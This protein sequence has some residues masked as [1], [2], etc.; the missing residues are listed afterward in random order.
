MKTIKITTT[1]I[2]T[3]TKGLI[4][5]TVLFDVVIDGKNYELRNGYDDDNYLIE[6]EWV[7]K[8]YKEMPAMDFSEEYTLGMMTGMQE[9]TFE[10]AQKAE[11]T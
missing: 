5:H 11:A 6:A 1:R 7:G 9:R 10:A 3:G 2:N 8:K 4:W